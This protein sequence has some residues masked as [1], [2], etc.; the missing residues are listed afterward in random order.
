M[1]SLAQAKKGAAAKAI[2]CLFECTQ[3]TQFEAFLDDSCV[4]EIAQI[5]NFQM[6]FD[7]QDKLDLQEETKHDP[8]IDQAALERL[9]E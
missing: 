1:T 2:S 6:Q 3:G 8:S 4:R 9:R 7:A 5:L